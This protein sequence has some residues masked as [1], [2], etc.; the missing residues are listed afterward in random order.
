MVRAAASDETSSGLRGPAAGQQVRLIL[1][2]GN[3]KTFNAFPDTIDDEIP[4][5]QGI[6][7]HRGLDK[8][9]EYATLSVILLDD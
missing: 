6:P 7:I 9:G 2:H 5:R 1:A 4:A 8:T 3:A